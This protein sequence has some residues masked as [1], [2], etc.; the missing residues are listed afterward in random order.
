MN[1]TKSDKIHV[2]LMI[3]LSLAVIITAVIGLFFAGALDNVFIASVTFIVVGISAVFIVYAARTLFRDIN[4]GLPFQDE[5]SKRVMEKAGSNSFIVMIYLLLALSLYIDYGTVSLLPTD[6][7]GIAIL[8]GSVSFLVF[9][10]F[11]HRRASL[12]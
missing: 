4:K 11:F 3:G 1:R 6:I 9:W 10:V 5:R 12:D 8:G 2:G 7:I